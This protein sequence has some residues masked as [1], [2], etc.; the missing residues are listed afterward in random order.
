[1]VLAASLYKM[2]SSPMKKDIGQNAHNA[3]NLPANLHA[4]KGTSIF[5]FILINGLVLKTL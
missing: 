3:I 2:L 5:W 1:M 4:V